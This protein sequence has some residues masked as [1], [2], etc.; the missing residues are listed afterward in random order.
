MRNSK[1]YSPVT[2]RANDTKDPKITL[3]QV[4]YLLVSVVKRICAKERASEQLNRKF[5]SSEFCLRQK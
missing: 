1:L 5:T 3:L 2:V 4:K